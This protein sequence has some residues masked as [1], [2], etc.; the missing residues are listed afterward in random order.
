M[1][2]RE[3]LHLTEFFPIGIELFSLQV[4]VVHGLE[5]RPDIDEALS[6]IC[7]CSCSVSDI[8]NQFILAVRRL[9]ELNHMSLGSLTLFRGGSSRNVEEHCYWQEIGGALLR[10]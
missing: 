4:Q 8:V 6:D 9:R 10:K 2:K 7:R 1:E 3:V 5:P